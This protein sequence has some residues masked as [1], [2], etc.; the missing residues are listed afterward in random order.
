MG[1]LY[2]RTFL[3]N[4]ATFLWRIEKCFG[5][6]I[7]VVCLQNTLLLLFILISSW[8]CTCALDVETFLEVE[9]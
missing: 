6:I 9:T 4:V 3:E 2:I 8:S 5:A 7:K 1:G